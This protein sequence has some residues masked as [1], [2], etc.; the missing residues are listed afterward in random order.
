MT[1][2]A[3]L[4]HNPDSG[5]LRAARLMRALGPDAA[6]IWAE[7]SPAETREL[8]AAM[9]FLADDPVA[10]ADAARAKLRRATRKWHALGERILAARLRGPHRSDDR[11]SSRP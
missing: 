7:L 11:G 2:P 5:T 1:L 6:G 3:T 4:S 8:T 10:E 9:D